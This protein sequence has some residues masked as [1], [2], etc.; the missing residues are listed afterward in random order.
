MKC[1]NCWNG[2]KW[3]GLAAKLLAPQFQLFIYLL[4]LLVDDGDLV[5]Q[6]GVKTVMIA[7]WLCLH[8][9]TPTHHNVQQVNTSWYFYLTS[10]RF[11]FFY[12][13]FLY[14]IFDKKNHLILLNIFL[15]ILYKAG[16]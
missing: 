5:Y 14:N 3:V 15:N 11:F 2:L 1:F 13:Y 16:S 4:F 9:S 12:L 7:A 8:S 6:M 10:F